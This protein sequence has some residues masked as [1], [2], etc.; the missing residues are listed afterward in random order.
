MLL[1]PGGAKF[2]NMVLQL[3]PNDI[4]SKFESFAVSGVY[5]MCLS[6]IQYQSE[7]D[8][9]I[10]LEGLLEHY[11]GALK[12]KMKARIQEVLATQLRTYVLSRV[13]TT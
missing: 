1:S 12:D 5:G 8:G 3:N 9:A 10:A 6:F 11:T 4:S 2:L 13:R 7:P